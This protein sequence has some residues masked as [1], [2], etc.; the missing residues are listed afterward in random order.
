MNK[1]KLPA[2]DDQCGWYH[3]LPPAK[4]ATLL[5][6]QQ[7]ADWV[8]LGG[9][10][11]GQAAARQLAQHK[12]NDRILLI[13]AQRVGNGASGR[14][15]GFVID[16]PHKF[17]LDHPDAERKQKLLRLN[18]AAIHFLEDAVTRHN[19][20][21]QWSRAGKYQGAVSE[22]GLKFLDHFERLLTELGRPFDV[23]D[24]PALK[25]LL[26]TD[27]YQRAIHTPGTILM[28]P[29]ALMRGLADALPENVEVLEDSPVTRL[30]TDGLGVSTLS[31]PNG[32]VRC[33]NLLLATNTFTAQFGF[34]KN[35]MVP[36]M[37]FAS[38]TRPLTDREFDAYGGQLDWGLTPADHAG[39]TVRMTQDRRLLIRSHYQYVPDYGSSDSK[40]SVVRASHRQ[41]LIERY[42]QLAQ[43]P[44]EHT[45][46][47]VCALSRNFTSFFGQLAPG[48]LASA[49]HNGVGAARG[50][51]SGKLM[52]DL[53]VGADSDLLRDM[54]IVSGM[55]ALNPPDPFLGVGVRSRMKW[56]EWSSRSER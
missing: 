51:I 48:V 56:A 41:S 20:D 15:S 36:V 26:G 5:R 23:L 11:I 13:D 55:P 37:T 28:Q 53:A 2:D 24:R 6:G 32:Q 35:R 49:C 4:P 52:A 1:I 29:A 3:S 54:Q 31:A 8:V 27:Y 30:E 42:P 34:L 10:F 44:F 45:W 50:T 17:D 18:Q 22:R 47:G 38:M 16:L 40:R 19:I 46:G 25:P 21:C 14:N 9:G 33:D 7:T 12:P 43:V 39:T